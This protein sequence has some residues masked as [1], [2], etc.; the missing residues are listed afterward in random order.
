MELYC[1]SMQH[2]A[3]TVKKFTLLQYNTFE[4]WRKALFF[5]LSAALIIFGLSSG[6]A[7]LSIASI[8]IGCI[9]LTNLNSRAISIADQVAE[10]MHGSFPLLRYTFRESGFTDGEDREEIPYGR[11]YRMIS[12][13]RYLYLFVSKAS[14]YMLDSESV[15]GENGQ[16]GLRQFLSEKSGLPW[17]KPVSLL[18]FRFHDILLLLKK[19]K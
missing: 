11:L 12:D 5:I 1:A 16:E 7:V 13:D 6:S 8:C 10:A 4:W 3:D 2:S 19:R 9:V 17:S 15:Q 14:G 18:T